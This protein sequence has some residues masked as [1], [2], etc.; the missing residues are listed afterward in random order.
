MNMKRLTQKKYS[1]SVL[2]ALNRTKII[3]LTKP[4]RD[5]WK[6]VLVKSHGMVADRI[7]KDVL[8]AI[9]KETGVVRK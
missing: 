1:P 9:Y 6:K 4:Q 3:T 8:Q 5:E 2:R 7:N